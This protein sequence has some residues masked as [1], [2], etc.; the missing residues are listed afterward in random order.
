MDKGTLK[1]ILLI[2]D[3]CSNIGEDPIAMAALAKEAGITVN[4]IGVM[5]HDVIDD[6]GMREIEAIAASGGGISQV[7]VAEQLS[8][9]V[10]MVTRKAMTQT[11]HGVINQELR[12]ILGTKTT[13]EELP[14]GERAEVMEVVD[15]LGEKSD[16]EVLIL[17][18]TS[19][20]MKPKLETVKEALLD[21]SLSLSARMGNNRFAVLIFPGK[22]KHVEKLLDWTPNMELLTSI[23]PK[24]AI[25]GLTPTG[26]AI[27]EAMGYFKKRR[28][29][30]GLLSDDDQYS[31]ESM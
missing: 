17:V 11:I 5:E 3:G 6:Q 10:Q 22:R 24:L 16:V 25:G 9:T 29:W 15:D 12:Q 2:T 30:K 14:P 31:E 7:V 28:S 26:P 19:A 20:S 27:K 18:D 21:L 23:F 1:Q 8:Q 4:V 13:I